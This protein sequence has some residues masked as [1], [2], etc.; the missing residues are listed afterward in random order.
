MSV[1]QFNFFIFLLFVVGGGLLVYP[2]NLHVYWDQCIYLLHSKFFA[3]QVIGYEEFK[4]RPILLSL[5]SSPIWGQTNSLYPFKFM[6]IAFSFFFIYSCYCFNRYFLIR[7]IALL[8]TA[9]VLFN[10]LLVYEARFFLTDIP[11]SALW[12]LGFYHMFQNKKM[13]P[14]WAGFFY[15]LSFMM[16]L[17]MLYFVPLFI[18]YYLLN[19]KY[20][21]MSFFLI[22]FCLFISPYQTWIYQNYGDLFINIFQAKHE[23]LNNAKYSFLKLKQIILT[24]GLFTTI[25]SVLGFIRSGKNFVLFAFIY[26]LVV[27][28]YNADN[29]RF[30]IP[31]LPFLYFGVGLFFSKKLKTNYLY[32]SALII[33]I[34]SIAIL[35]FWYVKI[36]EN[37]KEKQNIQIVSEYMAKNYA[38]YSPIVTSVSYP[39]FAFFTRKKTISPTLVVH[40]V[41][42]FNYVD[43]SLFGESK[44]PLV[45]AT[46][47]SMP[48]K[49]WLKGNNNYKQIG[50]YKEFYFF[51]PINANYKEG[52]KQYRA[53]FVENY[54]DKISK[55]NGYLE[56][57]SSNEVA[58][59]YF[60][61]IPSKKVREQLSDD[62][63][64]ESIRFGQSDN[65]ELTTF[66]N[67]EV[68]LVIMP[69]YIGDCKN[70]NNLKF[71]VR[72]KRIE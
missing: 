16:R 27:I 6:S 19:K 49:K 48:D 15:A 37:T 10:G 55:G 9:L 61:Y 65:Y 30:I 72:F 66:N 17:G 38:E 32:I 31:A 59:F 14:I 4:F 24:L 34:E 28:P 26:V 53:F 40:R 42:D 57:N 29:F 11:A 44:R 33:V 12:M 56:M 60:S 43:K 35:R 22:S 13:S 62:C 1:K 50:T 20:K 63:L 69:F 41:S 8:V 71:K 52:V 45:I 18:L 47:T 64:V 67:S 21:C 70:L 23:G 54:L 2:M 51:T 39:E 5:I 68:E 58:G 46:D 7:N 3:G 36:P 25:F